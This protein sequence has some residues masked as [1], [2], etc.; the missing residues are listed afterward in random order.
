MCKLHILKGSIFALPTLGG[1][2]GIKGHAKHKHFS[3]KRGS[4]LWLTSKPLG[5]FVNMRRDDRAP[6]QASHVRI[7][8][9]GVG[10]S[11]P[12]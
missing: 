11:R 6:P 2:L 1:W 4:L 7:P 12:R 5:S 8:G 3:L 9:G 10:V